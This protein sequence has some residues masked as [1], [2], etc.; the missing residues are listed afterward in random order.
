MKSCRIMILGNKR[1]FSSYQFCLVWVNMTGHKQV[2]STVK[3]LS[4]DDVVQ[5]S[6]RREQGYNHGQN[7]GLQEG[8]H[9]P[10][11]GSAWKNSRRHGPG[12]KRGLREL[13]DIQW[14]PPPNPRK[15]HP[16]KNQAKVAGDLHGCARSSWLNSGMKRKCTRSGNRS[17]GTRRIMDTLSKCWGMEP[18][19]P[20]TTWRWIW[21]GTWR[22]KRCASTGISGTKWRTGKTQAWPWWQKTQKRL[23]YMLPQSLLVR[24]AFNSP[25]PLRLRGNSGARSICPQRSTRGQG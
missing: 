12:E 24:L 20:K 4:W 5:D 11:Q 17:S 9:W 23:K 10:L 22:A 25:R 21:Q 19:K 7:P 3:L 8:R 1:I 16:D 13:F 18:E 15:T 2:V 6:A 14:W